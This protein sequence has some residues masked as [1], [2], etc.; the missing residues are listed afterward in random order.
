MRPQA[1]EGEAQHAISA[2]RQHLGLPLAP[3]YPR[4]S[5]QHLQHRNI[6][7]IILPCRVGWITPKVSRAL[8]VAFTHCT[9]PLKVLESSR[10]NRGHLITVQIKLSHSTGQE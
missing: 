3:R 7:T 4:Q 2:V 5:I 10:Y 9:D 1:S 8:P 6:R